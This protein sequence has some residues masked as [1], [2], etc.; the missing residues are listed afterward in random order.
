MSSS[1]S[2]Q[3]PVVAPSNVRQNERIRVEQEFKREQEIAQALQAK[4]PDHLRGSQICVQNVQ[5]C[6]A[7]DSIASPS[8]EIIKTHTQ[9]LKENN[10]QLANH[11][12]SY[13]QKA[14]QVKVNQLR[15][16]SDRRKHGLDAVIEKAEN[17]LQQKVASGDVLGSIEKMVKEI[18]ETLT[19]CSWSNCV[20]SYTIETNGKTVT[21]EFDNRYNLVPITI[22]LSSKIKE[23]ETRDISFAVT[24]SGK[25]NPALYRIQRL[26]PD[27]STPCPTA[28]LK[29]N[30][31]HTTSSSEDGQGTE[32]EQQKEISNYLRTYV[33][34]ELK[35]YFSEC[36]EDTDYENLYSENEQLCRNENTTVNQLKKSN[37]ALAIGYIEW[38]RRGMLRTYLSYDIDQIAVK[39]KISELLLNTK[40]EKN[41]LTLNEIKHII[42]TLYAGDE[43]LQNSKRVKS[44]TVNT[45]KNEVT[46]IVDGVGNVSCQLTGSFNALGEQDVEFTF[47]QKNDEKRAI[48]RIKRPASSSSQSY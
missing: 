43:L 37:L 33:P 45:H 1:N 41:D 40:V 7:L 6:F 8:L 36:V 28:E 15:K 34:L 30:P 26:A 44:Y 20:Q 10:E 35:K 31:S 13:Q 25:S 24:V 42:Q 14:L 11:F 38:K 18:K 16:T 4:I 39:S 47:K 2:S 12:I 32:L 27:S 19:L 21:F 3:A 48:Y 29:G 17:V 46:F 22:N 9:Q 23:N 5:R